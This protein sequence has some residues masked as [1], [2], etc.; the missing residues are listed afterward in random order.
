MKPFINIYIKRFSDV[1]EEDEDELKECI[2]SA[3][4]MINEHITDGLSY[5][6][7]CRK[8]GLEFCETMNEHCE[9]LLSNDKNYLN[10]Y[11]KFFE[12]DDVSIQIMALGSLK[13]LCDKETIEEELVK[14]FF[15]P[16]DDNFLKVIWTILG[17]KNTNVTIAAYKL[18][19]SISKLVVM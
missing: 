16:E 6:T 4:D 15:E 8:V 19:S 17:C 14:F 18:L 10:S 2:S 1:D 12:Y 13:D 7:L 3:S 11:K 9:F 5:Q